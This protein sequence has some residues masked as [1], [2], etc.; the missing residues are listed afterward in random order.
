MTKD[1]YPV[2]AA[3]E[4]KEFSVKI[5]ASFM[6]L[7]KIRREKV[8]AAVADLQALIALFEGNTQPS[9][10]LGLLTQ[11]MHELQM[12]ARNAESELTRLSHIITVA[13]GADVPQM[14]DFVV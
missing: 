9:D 2:V 5:V 4:M 8:Q 6:D 1:K 12:E 7:N 11:S 13:R 10:V 14:P 3:L